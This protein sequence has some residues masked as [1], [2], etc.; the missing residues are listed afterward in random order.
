MVEDI[1]VRCGGLDGENIVYGAPRNHLTEPPQ[2]IRDYIAQSLTRTALRINIT[3][4]CVRAFLNVT[5]ESPV[6]YH[7]Q[8]AE[9]P[10]LRSSGSA[11]RRTAEWAL[12]KLLTRLKNTP[13]ILC[14]IVHTWSLRGLRR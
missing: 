5:E 12:F 14:F 10:P 4:L 9:V 2:Q 6:L 11:L 13:D 7:E 8:P 1:R 3:D